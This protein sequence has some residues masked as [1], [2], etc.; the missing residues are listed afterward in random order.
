[1]ALSN[2]I[3]DN[4]FKKVS[5]EDKIIIDTEMY[6]IITKILDRYKEDRRVNIVHANLLCVFK[7]VDNTLQVII[8]DQPGH[9]KEA[10]HDIIIYTADEIRQQNINYIKR[11]RVDDP[12]EGM[13][14]LDIKV[15]L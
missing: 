6:S 13:I 11:V 1:M 5:D 10:L 7:W 14:Y 8:C 4:V 15:T 2:S 9:I 12:A 3:I